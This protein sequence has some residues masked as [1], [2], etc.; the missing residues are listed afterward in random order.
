MKILSNAMI[1]ETVLWKIIG[2]NFFRALSTSDLSTTSLFTFFSGLFVFVGKETSAQ[3]LHGSFTILLLTA[4]VLA[5]N[6]NPCRKMSH[7]DSRIGGVHALSAMTA[8]G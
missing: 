1:C 6:R 2:P 7:A 4:F 3:D 8:C 5:R